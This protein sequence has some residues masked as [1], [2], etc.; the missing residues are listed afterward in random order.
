MPAKKHFKIKNKWR[1]RARILPKVCGYDGEVGNFYSGVYRPDGTG[2]QASRALLGQFKGIPGQ[3]I[4]AKKYHDWA[5]Y[6]LRRLDSL[7]Q[8]RWPMNRSDDRCFTPS[9]RNL[10]SLDNGDPDAPNIGVGFGSTRKSEYNPQDVGRIYL[11]ENGGCVYIDLDHLEICLPEVKSAYDHVACWHA[12]LRITRRALD[13]ANRKLPEGRKIHVLINNSDGQGNSYGSHLN[14]LITEQCRQNI[15]ERR[16]HFLLYLAAYQVS[17][18][19]FT[20]QGKVGSEN[21]KPDVD[22]QLAQRA[23]F[24]AQLVGSQTTFSRPI[25]NSRDEP[26]CGTHLFLLNSDGQE[27]AEMARLHVIFFDNTLCHVSS[28]LKVGVM[29]ILL[30][31]IEAEFVNP[32]LLLDDPLH[33][34]LLWSRDLSFRAKSRMCSGRML[35]AL[36]LQFLFLEEAKKF[37]QNGGCEGAVPRAENILDLWE[38]TL[39]KLEARDLPALSKRLDWALKMWILERVMENHPDLHWKHP[40][41][42]QLDHVYSSLD[43]E[44][45]LFWAYDADNFIEHVVTRK[46]ID[47]FV[48]NPPEDTRAWT[49]AMLLRR[50]GE[51]HIESIDWDHIQ[52]TS[53]GNGF[54]FGRRTFDLA[55]PLKFTRAMSE[56]VLNRAGSIEA[57]LDALEVSGA[58][59]P[60]K[61]E[62]SHHEHS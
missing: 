12:M 49:R 19:I 62:E 47:R 1:K 29:Q 16:M 38:D 4:R 42:K 5:N 44:E 28:L 40:A 37:V 60:P 46:Q 56:P 3:R 39:I 21:N 33:A 10:L 9:S 35:T 53:I 61:E 30:A 34:L 17:S 51:D 45:G 23:D 2:K 27:E 52:F 55:N 7:S 11:P 6:Q 20:G 36:E 14:F 58:T 54:G 8:S 24:F 22:F 15:F 18:I 41:I 43:L 25:I 32:A 59:S 48:T 13:T 50:A 57:I 26:H 31:M